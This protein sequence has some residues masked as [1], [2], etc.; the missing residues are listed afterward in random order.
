MVGRTEQSWSGQANCF[1]LES[2]TLSKED[3]EDSRSPGTNWLLW[4]GDVHRTPDEL[5]DPCR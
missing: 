3:V 1:E 2:G 4:S 5:Q